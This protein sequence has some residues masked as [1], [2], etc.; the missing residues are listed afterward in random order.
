M[1]SQFTCMECAE[2]YYLSDNMCMKRKISP[3]NCSG[4]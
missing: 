2:G 4:Y 3:T 1:L